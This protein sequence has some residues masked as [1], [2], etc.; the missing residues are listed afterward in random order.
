VEKLMK[1]GLSYTL[2]TR[3]TG[4]LSRTLFYFRKSELMYI[5]E[6]LKKEKR[7]KVLD[8]GCNTGY[9]LEI[10]NQNAP[11]N[12]Y[13]GADINQ[14]A[15]NRANA[16]RKEFNFHFI[17]ENFFEKE[18]FDYIII[19]HV[20]EHIKEREDFI[21]NLSRL[22][23]VG[24]K[25]IIAIPQERIRGDATVFQLL[26]N[27]LRLRFENPHVVKLD[28]MDLKELMEEQEFKIVE[29]K[30]TNYL[31]PFKS[32]KKRFDAWSLVAVFQKEKN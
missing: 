26:Y 12:E 28:Y 15:L 16:K 32:N 21:K 6:I 2:I 7:K 8:Y 17:D 9:F 20:L 31:Y 27:L 5:V 30:Y 18:K 25:L 29:K 13:S 11:N 3:V 22:L 4:F 10:L 14:Y 19:S 1:Y 23:N 24:G